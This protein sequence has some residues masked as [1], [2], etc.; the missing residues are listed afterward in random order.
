MFI[1]LS[2][3]QVSRFDGQVGGVDAC[4]G[5]S[6]GPLWVDWDQRAT[7]VGVI[8]RGQSCAE[9]SKPGVYTR[10]KPFVDWIHETTKEFGC[11]TM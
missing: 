6:G 3:L 1:L 4:Q 7:Q 8:S 10:L 9:N 5:D 11:Y 2:L